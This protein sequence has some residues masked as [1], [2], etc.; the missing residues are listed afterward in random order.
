MS[1][2]DIGEFD[3]C[4]AMSIHFASPKPLFKSRETNASQGNVCMILWE[5]RPKKVRKTTTLRIGGRLKF[6][7]S[8]RGAM[9]Q[10]PTRSLSPD[11]VYVRSQ[12]MGLGQL[13]N[14]FT[15]Q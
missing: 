13:D 14:T 10:P 9:W 7:P 1:M 11:L 4:P 5:K 2:I 3:S 8:I 12:G 15:K 6:G